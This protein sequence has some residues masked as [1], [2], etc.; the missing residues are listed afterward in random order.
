MTTNNNQLTPIFRDFLQSYFVKDNN[1]SDQEWLKGKLQDSG[2]DL[3]DEELVK[4]TAD[5]VGSVKSFSETLHSLEQSKAQGKTA[6]AWLQEKIKENGK[7]INAEELQQF[8]DG[9]EQANERL[10]RNLNAEEN[11]QTVNTTVADVAAEQFLIDDFNEKAIAEE[12]RYEAIVDEV[13]ED[14][15]Y[16][17]DLFDIIIKDKFTGE[18][19]ESYQVVYGKDL[20]ETI[21]FVEETTAADQTVIVLESMVEEVQ[22]ACPLK[23]IASSIGGT[24]NVLIEGNPLQAD[25]ANS[26]TK[27]NTVAGVAK[28]ISNPEETIKNFADNAFTTGVLA[29]GFTGA[30][31]R[32]VEEQDVE[33]FSAS[34]LLEK[35]LLSEDNGGIKTAAAGALAT[36]VH[37]GI[38][39]VLP[40]D[41]SP[42]VVA[43]LASV[44]VENVKVL[45][46]V[47]DG[48]IT[49]DEGLEHMGNMNVAMGF[50]FVWN[51]FATP[52][53]AKLLN[54]IPVVGPIIS[55]KLVAGELLNF[56][57]QP[58]K[59]LVMEGVNKI[60]PAVKSVAKT[61]VKTAKKIGKK[62]KK[63]G[64]K[65]LKG[66]ASFFS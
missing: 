23:N 60:I 40:K 54:Y 26:I 42:V 39:T 41:V 38:V 37:K 7:E 22:K 43:D 49:M 29:A 35:A 57:K 62:A 27:I 46:Q 16:G 11:G 4:Y 28:L 48:T 59:E 13:A 47:A 64:K 44:G 19:L 61:V 5:L 32:M 56:V 50:E 1:L 3:N 31:E 18:K 6:D 34:D 30:F 15:V 58:V 53:A 66:I 52:V 55:N 9:L 45:S 8:S 24:G 25:I 63:I 17:N 14:S 51:K 2:L 12:E 65:I 33:E 10:L 20:K 21:D 36:A